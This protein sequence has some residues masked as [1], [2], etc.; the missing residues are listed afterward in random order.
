MCVHAFVCGFGSV[1][2]YE[3]V[4][5]YTLMS[6]WVDGSAWMCVLNDS[7]PGRRYMHDEQIE[8][9]VAVCILSGVAL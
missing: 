7:R 6:G 3:C 2:M 4:G 5:G 1:L 9:G 8:D